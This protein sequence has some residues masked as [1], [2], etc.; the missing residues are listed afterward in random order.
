M[1]MHYWPEE[2]VLLAAI[3]A[4]GIAET[5]KGRPLDV[6]ELVALAHHEARYN[7][8]RGENRAAL[9]LD[10]VEISRRAHAFLDW[11][12]AGYATDTTPAW[13]SNMTKAECR[14]YEAQQEEALLASVEALSTKF[15]A[16]AQLGQARL[17]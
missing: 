17:S 3:T 10:P 16:L 9:R 13:C 6:A 7:T 4:L 8:R 2:E 1:S 15:E 5:I 12:V 14:A 11:A